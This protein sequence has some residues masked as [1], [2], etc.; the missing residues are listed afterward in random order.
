MLSSLITW[1]SQ[2]DLEV[3]Y[4]SLYLV[5]MSLFSNTS[6]ALFKMNEFD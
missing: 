6:L 1:L 2:Q 3:P 5:I 4:Y